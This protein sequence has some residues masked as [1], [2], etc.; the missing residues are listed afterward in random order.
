MGSQLVRLVVSAQPPLPLSTGAK[1]ALVIMAT[2]AMDDGNPP[3]YW[4]GAVVLVL[5]M[6]SGD[7]ASNIRKA[8][9]YMAEL[10]EAG[11]IRNTGIRVGHRALYDLHIPGHHPGL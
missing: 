10:R 7:K 9:R 11:Y 3:E 4:G 1:W 6:P 8:R 5:N 2:V